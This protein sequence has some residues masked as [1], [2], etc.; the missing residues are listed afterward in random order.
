MAHV[1]PRMA[2]SRAGGRSDAAVLWGT[3][4]SSRSPTAK[5]GKGR[6]LGLQGPRVDHPGC[7]AMEWWLLTPLPGRQK[8][9]EVPVSSWG[10]PGGMPYPLQWGRG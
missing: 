4:K 2:G 10:L 1:L 6:A 8:A 5:R 3:V 9:R 7:G